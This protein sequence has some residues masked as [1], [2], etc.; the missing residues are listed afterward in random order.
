[1]TDSGD[2][3]CCFATSGVSG[4]ITFSNAYPLLTQQARDTLAANGITQFRLSR[5]LADVSNLGTSSESEM[6]RAVIGVEGKFELGGRPFSWE[7]S[8]NLGRYESTYHRNQL[9]QQHFVNALNVVRDTSGNVVCSPTSEK[10]PLL[11][12][13]SRMSARGPAQRPHR[14]R[15]STTST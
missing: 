13:R 7:A 12:Q 2:T 9:N 5:S 4:Q 3:N 6:K 15:L 8:A 14:N 10:A 11:R 1:M